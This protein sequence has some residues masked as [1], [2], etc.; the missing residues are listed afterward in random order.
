MR[1]LSELEGAVLGVVAQHGPLTPYAVRQEFARSPNP[2]WTASAGSIY[3]LLR[4]LERQRFVSARA[5]AT[6]AR[7]GQKYSLTAA[8]RKLLRTWILEAQDEKIASTSDLLRLRVHFLAALS[9]AERV[10]F[11]DTALATMRREVTKISAFCRKKEKAGDL[12]DHIATRGTVL[13][14]RAR[15]AWLREVRKCVTH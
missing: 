12:F 3:P 7:R 1:N 5:H 11:I 2:H 9:P 8:G 4:R 14:T 15:L 6:G 13:M 10:R